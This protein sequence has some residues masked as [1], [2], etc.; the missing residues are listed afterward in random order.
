[1]R[2]P[3]NEFLDALE[4][5]GLKFTA[6]S[7]AGH[8]GGKFDDKNYSVDLNPRGVGQKD[9]RGFYNV[10]GT[11]QF[12]LKLAEVAKKEGFEWKA[13]YNDYKVAGVVNEKL[14]ASRVRFVKQHGP[15]PY[16]LHIHLDLMVTK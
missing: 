4:A 12:F 3:V 2:A 11:V 10:D 13:L 1:M 6:G 7:Y 15:A 8:G 14:G 16:V 9:E 5:A